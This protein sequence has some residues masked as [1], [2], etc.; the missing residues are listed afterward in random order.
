[1]KAITWNIRGLNS[2]RKQRILRNKLKQEQPNLCFIQE[3]RCN[4]DRMEA[5]S[6]Q[7][8][9]KY[10][11][12]AIEG[13]QMAG[14]IL[15][16]WNPQVLS[17]IAAEVTRHTLTV[18]MQIIG[19]TEVILC[20]NVYGPQVSEEKR[21]M[22]RDLE[23]LKTRSNNL[24]WIL[25]GDFDIITSLAEKKGGTRRLDR[26]VKEFSKFIDTVEMV[27]LK[28]NNGQFTWNNK[29]MNQY[30]VATRLDRFLVSESIIMQGLTLDCNILPWGGSDHWPMQLEAG[31][32]T[33]PK[34]RP[35]RFEKFWIEHPTFKE[36]IKQWWREE[37][38]E[39]G[40]RM[41]K[42][43]KKLKY[44]KYRLKEWNKDTFGNINREKNNIEEKMKKLQ[45]TCILEGCTEEWKKEE[46]QMTQ[47]W[48]ARC[49]QEETLSRQKS[50]I[51][52][53]KKGKR[54]TK[55][56]HRTTMVRTRME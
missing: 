19:N 6:K 34:N 8:W 35:F 30:Q 33:T 40:T 15:T 32:Q 23:D 37:Q 42:L 54:N 36:I 4:T 27:D 41:F 47:E 25:A 1:M 31:F 56:F 18:R 2:P 14:G 11:M 5:I 26:D 44:I 48:E 38:P 24:Q 29:R 51:R 43:Y 53:L 16:L 49:Q 22:I 10:K 9:R 46:I 13:H 28:T 21:G 12:V 17:L 55:F 3:T 20:T 52:W 39:Q 50:R 45:E 7:H